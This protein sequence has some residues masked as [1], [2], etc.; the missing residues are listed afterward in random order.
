MVSFYID[1]PEDE[2][3]FVWVKKGDELR[4]RVARAGD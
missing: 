1:E 2:D 4:F 3:G